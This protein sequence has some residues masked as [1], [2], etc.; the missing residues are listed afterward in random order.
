MF[1][2]P[3]AMSVLECSLIEAFQ[4]LEVIIPRMFNLTGSSTSIYVV[5]HTNL[6]IKGTVTQII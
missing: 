1:K 6:V 4:V 5:I 3:L 2:G